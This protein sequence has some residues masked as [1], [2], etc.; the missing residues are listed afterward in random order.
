[1]SRFAPPLSESRCFVIA[2]VGSNHMGDFLCAVEHVETA[3]RA[4]ANAIKFQLFRPE[5]ILIDPSKCDLRT[6]LDPAWIPRLHAACLEMRVEFMCTPFSAWAVDILDPY[7]N[8][9]KVGSFEHARADVIDAVEA[10]RKPVIA[11][12]GRGT[13]MTDEPW[14]L[15]YCV[16]KY[17]AEPADICL[18]EFQPHGRYAGFS[19][20]TVS[21]V[22]PS[23]AVA[24]G[25]IIIEKHYRI[26]SAD[27]S[28]PDYPHSLD[29]MQF[30]EMV[31][32]IRLAEAT[33][34]RPPATSQVPSRYPNRRE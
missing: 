7:V 10:T 33:C 11:S 16:S 3:A 12:C 27:P 13:P 28:S 23:L 2:E 31:K 22:L 18:P 29:T 21:T 4:G 30:S 19:D 5:D 20:H 25:A 34:L 32:N 9:W 6:V 1:M 8:L 26:P 17:P 24:K 14:H 15:L